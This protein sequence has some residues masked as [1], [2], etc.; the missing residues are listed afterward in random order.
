MCPSPPT[1]SVRNGKDVERFHEE[2]EEDEDMRARINI[3]KNPDNPAAAAAAAQDEGMDDDEDEG[4][5]P[6]VPLEELLDAL[7]I[8]SAAK[9]QQGQEWGGVP[10]GYQPPTGDDEDVDMMED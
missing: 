3:F 2:L 7:T 9:A 6:D 1:P 10:A 4:S 8:N 5:I